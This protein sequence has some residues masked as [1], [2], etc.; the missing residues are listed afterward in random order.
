VTPHINKVLKEGDVS[1]IHP[2]STCTNMKGPVDV[3]IFHV[4]TPYRNRQS[5]DMQLSSE[6]QKEGNVGRNRLFRDSDTHIQ[7]DAAPQTVITKCESAT[8]ET[9]AEF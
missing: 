3:F 1:Y 8:R 5:V 6:C 7:D 9:W 2:A 4:K